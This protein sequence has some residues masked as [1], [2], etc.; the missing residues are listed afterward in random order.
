MQVAALKQDK[1]LTK[2]FIKYLNFS[3]VFS[4]KN[5]LVLLEQ[6]DLNEHVIELEKN[7]QPLYSLIYS[8]GPVEFET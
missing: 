8:L 6:T 1:A 3:D 2:V 4:K 7:K 5:A